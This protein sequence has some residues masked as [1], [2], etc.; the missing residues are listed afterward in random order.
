MV[1]ISLGEG[2][3]AFERAGHLE[4]IDIDECFEVNPCRTNENCVNLPGSYDCDCRTGLEYNHKN[5]PRIQKLTSWTWRNLPVVRSAVK[6]IDI[7]E[8]AN[9]LLKSEGVQ[10]ACQ[11][12]AECVNAFGYYMCHCISGAFPSDLI[13]SNKIKTLWKP[14]R[15]YQCWRRMRRHR[16]VFIISLWWRIRRNGRLCRRV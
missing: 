5:E 12:N 8:C 3:K 7:D 1:H 4:C 9:D 2:Y 15:L 11:S 10:R 16:W 13:S 6:C 14:R